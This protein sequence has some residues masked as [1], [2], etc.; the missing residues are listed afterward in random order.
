MVLWQEQE[1]WSQIEPF[2]LAS[3]ENMEGLDCLQKL[4]ETIAEGLARLDGPLQSLCGVTCSDCDDNCCVRAT[5]WYD[6]KDLLFLFFHRGTLPRQQIIRSKSRSCPNLT[7]QGC[8]LPR[9]DRPFVCTWY[10]CPR[11]KELLSETGEKSILL[12]LVKTIQHIQL[13]RK[14]LED[15][16]AD[17]TLKK[18]NILS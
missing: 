12:E 3:C 1:D 16:F 8:R 10:L 13:T 4:A 5:I 2:L 14:T 18:K 7:S 17:E 9:L 15:I 6:L 11:Q